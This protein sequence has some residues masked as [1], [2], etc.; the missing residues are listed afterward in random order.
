MKKLEEAILK[1]IEC[2][3]ELCEINNNNLIN[4]LIICK[5]VSAAEKILEDVCKQNNVC[6]ITIDLLNEPDIKISLEDLFDKLNN[7]NSILYLKN[8][9]ETETRLRYRF[10][11]IYKDN[12]A[13]NRFGAVTKTGLKY[14]GTILLTSETLKYPLDMSECSCFA[15]I[16]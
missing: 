15:N 1:Q 4:K 8:Y 14:L 11:C 13:T 7:S 10:S 16:K 12:L 2:N 5:D 3:R 6:L 9:T